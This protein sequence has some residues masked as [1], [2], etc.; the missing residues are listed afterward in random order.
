MMTLREN[1]INSKRIYE[2]RI[3]SLRVDTVELPDK[4]YSTREIIEHPGAA[5]VVPITDEG[6]IIMVKQFRKPVEDFLI[7]V[8]AGKLD[9]GEEPLLCAHRELKEETGY[10]S[11]NMQHL[12]TFFSSP[13]FA[14]ETMHLFIA[15]DLT[16]GEAIPDEDEYIEIE[17]YELNQLIHMIFNGQIKDA[18]S[19]IAIFAVKQFL[20]STSDR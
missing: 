17:S 2:G 19:I 15:R 20:Q 18:K 13:G 6:K 5:V 4:K 3:I 1:T 9:K 8:P 10:S 7:E 12:F 11:G 14:N 16:V